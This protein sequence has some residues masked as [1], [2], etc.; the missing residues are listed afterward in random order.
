MQEDEGDDDGD[1]EEAAEDAA[2]A[3]TPAKKQ[4]KASEEHSTKKPTVTQVCAA[5]LALG[6]TTLVALAHVSASLKR[7]PPNPRLSQLCWD[8]ATRW[9]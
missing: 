4:K 6:A 5:S 1:D 8:R 3:A 2:P 7:P 9:K